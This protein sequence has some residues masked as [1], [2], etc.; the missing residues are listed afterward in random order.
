MLGYI[1]SPTMIM[2]KSYH[3][4][5]FKPIKCIFLFIIMRNENITL[6]EGDGGYKSGELISEIR[7]ILD[8]SSKNK[9]W[10]NCEDDAAVFKLKGNKKLVFTTDA[11]IV[12][13]I[14]FP[15]G[16]IGKIAMSGTINDLSVMG[17]NP[18]GISLSI[19]V[20]EGFPKSDL[21][22]IVQSIAE[23]SKKSGVPVVTGDTKVSEKG[24]IDKIEITTAGVGLADNIISNNG[25]KNGDYI[26]S[27]G[28]LGEHTVALLAKRFNY[29]TKIKSDSKPF[30]KEIEKV[31]KY[32][33]ACKDP[34]RGG[35]A[36][37]L[38]EMAEKSGVK[39]VLEEKS[40]PY[41]KEVMAI[42][43]LLGLDVFSLASE[44]RFIASV[45][46]KNI[47]KVLKILQ[48]FNLEAKVIGRVEKGKTGT[49]KGNE[50]GVYLK[51][52]LGSLRPIEMPKGKLIPRI[53]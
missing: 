20:E 18:I 13:P 26:I 43:N 24:K 48:R 16:D 6:D 2:L 45:S 35:L 28:D 15:G 11:Y 37:N 41:K 3:N 33:N 50:R 27:S 5:E 39:V 38:V 7:K 49:K 14:F 42:T 47:K 30:N 40:L 19:V 52:N 17:A 22:K 53:C 32:L 10:N 25:I 23:V 21:Q 12:D 9:K 46:P 51:T 29:K 4:L 34:T 36:A 44:G 31:G 1:Y 8:F